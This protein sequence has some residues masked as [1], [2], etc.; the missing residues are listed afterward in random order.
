MSNRY[1][2]VVVHKDQVNW[3]VTP[4]AD[5]TP[6]RGNALASGDDAEDRKAEDSILRRLRLGQVWAWC[7]VEVKGFW[8]GLTA[9]AYLGCCSYRN[10]ADFEK[11]GYY[12][13]LQ[14]EVV[15]ILQSMVDRILHD[16]DVAPIVRDDI[17]R[18]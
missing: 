17:M 7:T 8:R 12:E 3:T 18:T 13:D 6:V 4:Y 14:H 5:P 11:G 15:E 1:K 9:S 2:P 10:R 16:T